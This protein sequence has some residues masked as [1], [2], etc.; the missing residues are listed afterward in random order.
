V[1][2]AK[3]SPHCEIGPNLTGIIVISVNNSNGCVT[4]DGSMSYD[5]DGDPLTY[6]WLADLD[7]DGAKEPFASGAIVT[8]CFDLGTFEVCLVVDDG[9]CADTNSITVE[10]LSACE[11]VERL[12]EKVNNADLGRRNKRPLIASLKAACAS[13]DRGNCVSGVNQLQA[14]QHKVRAQIGRVNPALADELIALTQKVLDCIDCEK[15][16]NGIGNGTDPQP[17]GNPPP[18]D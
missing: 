10:V 15:G 8:N 11:A 14:F 18:N 12:I 4:L 2:V 1:A 17:P 7:G 13:F 3:A 5:P 6:V 16:N 9:R